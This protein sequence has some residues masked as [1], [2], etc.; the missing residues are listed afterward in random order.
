MGYN[1]GMDP[2]KIADIGTDGIDNLVIDRPSG[3]SGQK[4][5]DRDKVVALRRKGLSMR[6]IAKI[7][8]CSQQA[9]FYHLHQAGAD[10]EQIDSYKANRADYL[11]ALQLRM[12]SSLSPADVAKMP[13]GSRV[14]AACQLYD[15]ERLERGKTTNNTAM[16][17]LQ[18][19]DTRD[20]YNKIIDQQSAV[21]PAPEEGEE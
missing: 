20:E 13:G 3:Y 21:S 12:L 16:L 11:A 15:K 6:E 19:P 2:S 1:I 7:L 18:I 9:I 14:L 4:N 17:V 10:Q 5:I 8:G